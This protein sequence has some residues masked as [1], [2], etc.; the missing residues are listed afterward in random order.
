MLEAGDHYAFEGILSCMGHG[1]N[2]NESATCILGLGQGAT[3]HVTPAAVPDNGS[4]T[5]WGSLLLE[6]LTIKGAGI[7]VP[8]HCQLLAE[9]CRFEGGNGSADAG[10]QGVSG[11]AQSTIDLNHCDVLGPFFSGVIAVGQVSLSHCR[12]EGCR[13]GI[14]C[15][16]TAKLTAESCRLRYNKSAGLIVGDATKPVM[17][18]NCIISSNE[19]HG[20]QLADKA[21][22]GASCKAMHTIQGSSVHHNAGCG[23]VAKTGPTTTVQLIDCE[24]FENAAWGIR[25]DA[26]TKLCITGGHI[27]ANRGTA[28]LSHWLP[29]A[30]KK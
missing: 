28:L 7:D 6:G 27:V 11:K 3:L 30:E 17:L 19:G 21:T 13:V 4:G 14:S 15:M 12:I 20:V 10:L 9:S 23:L 26:E 24:V 18:S 25:L 5:I 8:A 29:D 2:V 1:R 22:A 16:S